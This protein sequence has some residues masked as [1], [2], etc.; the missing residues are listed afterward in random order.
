MQKLSAPRHCW[1]LKASSA[2]CLAGGS[3]ALPCHSLPCLRWLANG[4]WWALAH[5][6]LVASGLAVGKLLI[7]LPGWVCLVCDHFYLGPLALLAS[8]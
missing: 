8:R 7:R 1:P 5:T 3:P 6:A 4:G 2:R